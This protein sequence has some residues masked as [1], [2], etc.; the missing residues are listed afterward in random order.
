[1]NQQVAA[2]PAVLPSI[3]H[4]SGQLNIEQ[5]LLDRAKRN[6]RDALEMMFRQFIPPEEDI[7]FVEF[8]G[9]QG[10]WWAGK[11]SFACLTNRRIASIMV[12]AWGEVTFQDGVLE[13]Y[14][15]GMI[16][17]PGLL[18]LYVF[19]ALWV[20]FSLSLLGLPLLLL[21]YVVQYYYRV[22]K[23]GLV[24]AIREGIAVYLFSNRNRLVRANQLYRLAAGQYERHLHE[25]PRIAGV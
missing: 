3:Q 21:P 17:Q 13:H 25:L 8:F 22:N 5:S 10:M 14:N 20:V 18:M 12:G 6:D 2:N 19:V 15:S 7:L 4:E 23:C 16:H 9:T 1:M 24:W 11:N